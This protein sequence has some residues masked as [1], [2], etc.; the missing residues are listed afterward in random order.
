MIAILATYTDDSEVIKEKIAQVCYLFK[1]KKEY[2]ERAFSVKELGDYFIIALKQESL[3][4]GVKLDLPDTSH[5][6]E[7]KQKQMQKLVG[8]YYK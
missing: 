1:Y 4:R 5:L 3:F 8:A 7:E 6:K 2:V